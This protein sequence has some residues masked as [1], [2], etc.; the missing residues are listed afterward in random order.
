MT[1]ELLLQKMSF[2]TDS[3][4]NIIALGIANTQYDTAEVVRQLFEMLQDNYA[5][6]TILIGHELVQYVEHE[7]SLLYGNAVQTMYNK[8]ATQ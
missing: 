7:Y 1:K 4:P 8:T 6:T 3:K 2:T 5:A